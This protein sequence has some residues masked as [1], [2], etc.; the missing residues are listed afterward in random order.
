MAKKNA[1]NNRQQAP[2]KGGVLSSLADIESAGGAQVVEVEAWGGY[3]RLGSLTAELTMGR[4]ELAG[5]TEEATN[6]LRGLWMIAA[7]LVNDEGK[8]ICPDAAS[9]ER[10]V[11][12]LKQ[13]D[14]PTITRISRALSE[15]NG[16]GE[17]D[18]VKN[19]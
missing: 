8:H 2:A 1:N 12:V 10:M 9:R 14:M 5:E 15:L 4:S 19:G 17:V 7:S 3:V 13:K 6:A 16:F 18:A 11:H